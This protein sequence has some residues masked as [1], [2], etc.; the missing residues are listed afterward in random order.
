[1]LLDFVDRIVFV[2]VLFDHDN[3]VDPGIRVFS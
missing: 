1:M 3:A 2:L